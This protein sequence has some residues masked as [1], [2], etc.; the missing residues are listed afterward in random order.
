MEI[1]IIVIVILVVAIYYGLFDSVE[2]GARMA[3]RKV[4]RLEAEQ[5]QS[6]IKY[7]N[8]HKINDEKFDEAITQKELLKAYRDM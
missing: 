2:T 7:Y 8:D 4:E 5:I 1:A 3:N 6:D